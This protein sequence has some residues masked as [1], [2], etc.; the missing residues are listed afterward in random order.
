MLFAVVI[1]SA[2]VNVRPSAEDFTTLG[3]LGKPGMTERMFAA[4]ERGAQVNL[5]LSD[6]W[7]YWAYAGLPLEEARRRLNIPPKG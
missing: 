4:I 1:F 6:K 5:D 3:V 2:G 7:D